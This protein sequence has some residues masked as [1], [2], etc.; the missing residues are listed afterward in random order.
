MCTYVH[1]FAYD[2]SSLNLTELKKV[3]H[4][5]KA[6]GLWQ[7]LQNL[8]RK[9]NLKTSSCKLRGD[10]EPRKSV[11]LFIDR[12]FITHSPISTKQASTWIF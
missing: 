9:Q 2:I 8:S 7:L 10:C 12:P 4:E 1:I 5:I 3:I 11:Q 6:N